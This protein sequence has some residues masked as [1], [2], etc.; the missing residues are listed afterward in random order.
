MRYH[1]SSDGDP[2]KRFWKNVA[3]SGDCWL[4]QGATDADGTGLFL[5]RG[6]LR[7]APAVAFFFETGDAAWER[8]L[9]YHHHCKNI[10]CVRPDHVY[11]GP[12]LPDGLPRRSAKRS[13]VDIRKPSSSQEWK[14]KLRLDM[15]AE[16]H[17]TDDDTQRFLINDPDL[18]VDAALEPDPIP[19]RRR[20]CEITGELCDC[21]G[22]CPNDI[23]EDAPTNPFIRIRK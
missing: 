13:G 6:E 23:D 19:L 11:L 14:L 12:P 21:E 20:R 18:F 8:G 7:A 5:F 22:D 3:F 2:K 1:H 16:D 17:P 4:W 15:H 10:R 9:C